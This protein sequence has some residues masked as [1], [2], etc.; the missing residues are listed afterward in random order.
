MGLK[1]YNYGREMGMTEFMK[2]L[3]KQAIGG[4]EGLR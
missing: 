1:D 2:R 4:G 3:E